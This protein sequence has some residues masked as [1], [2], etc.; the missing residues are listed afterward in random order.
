VEATISAFEPRLVNVS[1]SISPAAPAAKVVHFQIE[2]LLRTEPAPERVYFDSTLE[3]S[4]G[5]YEIEGET[6]AG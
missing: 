1:V 3:L 4:S 5:E 6:R 2:A